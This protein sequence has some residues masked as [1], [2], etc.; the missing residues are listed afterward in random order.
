MA[1]DS[2]EFVRGRKTLGRLLGHYKQHGCCI[3]LVGDVPDKTLD[4]ASAN[5]LGDP[6]TDQRTRVFG[7]FDRNERT[8]YDR[9]E[10]AGYSQTPTKVVTTTAFARMS[11]TAETETETD[12]GSSGPDSTNAD[13]SLDVTTVTSDDLA[14]VTTA[15]VDAF[16]A[17]EDYT[18]SELRV[19]IDSLRPLLDECDADTVGAF[20]DTLTAEIVARQGMGH[21]VLP[22]APDHECV[23][24]VRDH[25]DIVVPIRCENGTEEQR[26]VFPSED[27]K[28][29]WLEL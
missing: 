16:G 8:I 9:L 28:T 1:A 4:H 6:A 29:D 24:A 14:A 7:L 25:F 21:V 12:G 5:F 26:W 15:L 20:L 17:A 22:V 3:L 19:C 2:R 27:R 18:P 10:Y 13:Y 23:E 11:A